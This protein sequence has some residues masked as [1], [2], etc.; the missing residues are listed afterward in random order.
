MFQTF[1]LAGLWMTGRLQVCSLLIYF[2]VEHVRLGPQGNRPVKVS[3]PKVF[4][5]NG[6]DVSLKGMCLIF[7]RIKPENEVTDAN[8]NNVSR[9]AMLSLTQ[10]LPKTWFTWNL[11]LNFDY[12]EMH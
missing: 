12:F 8:I 3:K 7:T 5:T 9:K 6:T 2:P 4:I 11:H 1:V 10:V